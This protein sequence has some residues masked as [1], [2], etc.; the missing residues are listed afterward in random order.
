MVVLRVGGG[1]YLEN[2]AT[3]LSIFGP[4]LGSQ[5][6]TRGKILAEGVKE[7]FGIK[8]TPWKHGKGG[9]HLLTRMGGGR[10]G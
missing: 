4:F 5:Q 6:F 8:S 10:G 2:L 3:I 1:V 9:R 7:N